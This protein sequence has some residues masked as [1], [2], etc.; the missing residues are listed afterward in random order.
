MANKREKHLP[1]G[2]FLPLEEAISEITGKD[3]SLLSSI[4][5]SFRSTDCSRIIEE[6]VFAW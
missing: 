1:W 6:P 3:Q 4:L 2:D 5:G